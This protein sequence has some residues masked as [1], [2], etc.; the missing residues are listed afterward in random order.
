MKQEPNRSRG[1][2][3]DS[4]DPVC[5]R[6]QDCVWKQQVLPSDVSLQKGLSSSAKFRLFLRVT[7]SASWLHRTATM[8]TKESWT[9][10][11]TDWTHTAMTERSRN[12]PTHRALSPVRHS[13]DSRLFHC[14]G[15]LLLYFQTA[16]MLN[17]YVHFLCGS[18]TIR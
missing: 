3:R 16:A 6:G 4:R 12:Q 14:S 2:S 7:L 11:C 10:S 1:R 8:G 15:Q 17:L 9:N 18:K 5:Q 13:G